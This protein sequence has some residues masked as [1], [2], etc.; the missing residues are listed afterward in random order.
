MV[1]K[2][3]V[4]YS[5]SVNGEWFFKEK[6]FNDYKDAFEFMTSQDQVY[7]FQVSFIRNNK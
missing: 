2:I 6:Y 4:K 3:I 1:K 5:I 7:R